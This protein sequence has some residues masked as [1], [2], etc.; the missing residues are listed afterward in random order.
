MSHS[1]LLDSDSFNKLNLF[2]YK[3]QAKQAHI[4]QYK[5]GLCILNTASHKKA[6]KPK[7]KKHKKVKK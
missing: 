1:F 5:S 2:L 3:F 4:K 6:A 7:Y